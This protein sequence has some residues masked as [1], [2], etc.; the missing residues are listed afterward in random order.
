[1]YLILKELLFSTEYGTESQTYSDNKYLLYQIDTM[2][3]SLQKHSISL[4]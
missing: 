4:L 1:M 2:I 3:C